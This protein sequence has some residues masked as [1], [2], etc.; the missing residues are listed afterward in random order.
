VS[1]SSHRRFLYD[2][3]ACAAI[4]LGRAVP[5]EE[6]L[7]VT[8]EL[9]TIPA[10]WSRLKCQMLDRGDAPLVYSLWLCRRCSAPPEASRILV[11]L[12]FQIRILS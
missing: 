3:A 8:G 7:F 1:V 5:T 2:C 9:D 6:P 10:G 11:A 4:E 12:R